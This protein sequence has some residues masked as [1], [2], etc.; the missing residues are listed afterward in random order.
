[1]D[2]IN[3][4]KERDHIPRLAVTKWFISTNNTYICSHRF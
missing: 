2:K 3:F 1:M 4:L